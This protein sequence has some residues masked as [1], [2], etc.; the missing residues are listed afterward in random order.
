[1]KRDEIF[2]R[3]ILENISLIQQSL[4]NVKKQDFL[5]DREKQD[6]NLRRLEIIGEAAKNISNRLKQK[7][8]SVPWKE[9]AGTRDKLIHNYFGVDLELTWEIIKVDLPKLKKEIEKI[10]GEVV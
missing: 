2:L 6:A 4:L 1:M 5:K 8:S 9:I 7:Y 3:H 10:L